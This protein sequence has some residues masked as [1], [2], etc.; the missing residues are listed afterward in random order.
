MNDNMNSNLN[1]NK[2]KT[3]YN[4]SLS[5]NIINLN[6]EPK[7]DLIACI[8][9]RKE[10]NITG[11]FHKII[12]KNKTGC[13]E[14]TI[15]GLLILFI[16]IG[17]INFS[18]VI[19][20]LLTS[21]KKNKYYQAFRTEVMVLQA[22]YSSSDKLVFPSFT[23]FW[24]DVGKVEDGI[25]ISYIIFHTLFLGFEIFSL[26]LHNNVITIEIKGLFYN[27]IVLVNIIFLI[28][29]YIYIPLFIFLF[30]YSLLVLSVSPLDV[31]YDGKSDRIKST[32][33]NE[34][35]E[36]KTTSIVNLIIIII[37][38]I[39]VQLQTSIKSIILIYLNMSF[40]END[41]AKNSIKKST[42][43]INNKNMNI[44]VKA[45]QLLYLKE[46]GSNIFYK[47]KEMKIEGV[48]D[49]DFVFIR[50]DNEAIIDILSFTDWEYSYFNETFMKLAKLSK[51][52]YGILIVSI[53]A[54]KMHIK[55]EISYKLILDVKDTFTNSDKE[56][57]KLFDVF[58][59][60][61]SLEKGFTESRFALYIISLFLILL[62]M[63]KRIFFG[64]FSK[65][66]Y[67]LISFICL[68]VFLLLNLIYTILSIVMIF[69]SILS[70]A[71][72]NDIFKDIK[73][74]VIPAKLYMQIFINI[75]ISG[76]I[77][78]LLVHNI[79][80]LQSFNKI[81]N[82][83]KNL[84]NNTNSEDVAIKM[85]FKY[86]GLDQQE[87]VLYEYEI[88]GHPKYL[89]YTLNNNNANKSVN[90]QILDLNNNNEKQNY[91]SN[92]NNNNNNKNNNVV[93]SLQNTK[94]ENEKE[95]KIKTLERRNS[96]KPTKRNSKINRK[97]DDNIE[98][99]I[100][101]ENNSLRSENNNLKIELE[102][103]KN[104]LNSM[105]DS[106]KA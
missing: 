34:W 46:V 102:R 85:G 87:H 53:F 45:N 22:T 84:N 6:N 78:A 98:E 28:I 33:E 10:E 25:L 92:N 36:H 29:F 44:E 54:F 71:S 47:F 15:I 35:D 43:L 59:I 52:I 9:M 13:C 26:L 41:S 103:L 76:I 40:E 64:G 20:S 31:N 101:N 75:T 93:I 89:Y 70:L 62:S 12:A 90:T 77:I 88:E 42:I 72:S 4:T 58:I 27:I 48:N 14:K 104:Q 7:N 80:L 91:N 66:I 37:I 50:L 17:T 30:L 21:I 57:P 32:L 3:D 55:K 96:K 8:E 67:S 16:I 100:Q 5:V 95:N 82:E 60:Y 24:C 81:R 97:I 11:C 1:R 94:N 69:L 63:L 106:I 73:E 68:T 19:A 38:Y 51:L 49:D 99:R 56:K 74:D 2:N 79:Q 65:S 39:C 61:G 18:L 83:V 23:K 86:T 105:I